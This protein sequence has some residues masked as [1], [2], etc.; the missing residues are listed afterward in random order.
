MILKGK[1]SSEGWYMAFLIRVRVFFFTYI[2]PKS[3]ESSSRGPISTP[4]MFIFIGSLVHKAVK[5][6]R[7]R[8]KEV[9]KWKFLLRISP[10]WVGPP[11]PKI[12]F[13][14]LYLFKVLLKERK[15]VQKWVFSPFV[16]FSWPHIILYLNL[17]IRQNR[18]CRENKK[19]ITECLILINVWFFGHLTVS[20][21]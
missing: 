12:S 4:K 14:S 1:V 11:S 8:E 19:L 7:E 20:C 15:K 17:S 2:L 5:K 6:E 3:L 10:Y 13:D 16:S 18:W 21:L 9:K